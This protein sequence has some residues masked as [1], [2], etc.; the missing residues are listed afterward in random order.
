MPPTL[1][2]VIHGGAV[3]FLNA[4]AQHGGS[5]ISHI[6]ASS[7]HLGK[8]RCS[9]VVHNGI[10]EV[11]AGGGSNLHGPHLLRTILSR[12]ACSTHFF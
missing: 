9:L 4:T 1:T 8:V 12:E 6:A 10:L 5:T 2:A 11:T 3:V 7:L